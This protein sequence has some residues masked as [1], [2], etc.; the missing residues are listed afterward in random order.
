MKTS[1]TGSARSSYIKHALSNNIMEAKCRRIPV[2][3][4]V[5]LGD[6]DERGSSPVKPRTSPFQ[7]PNREKSA[8]TLYTLEIVVSYVHNFIVEC[9]QF[10]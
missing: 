4:P 8:Q 3:P 10:C 2:T 6:E 1:E 9:I 5:G 7:K